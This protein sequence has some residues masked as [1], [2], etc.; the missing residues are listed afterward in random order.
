MKNVLII[1]YFFPPM[2]GSGVQ[3]TLKFVKYL[4]EFNYNPIILTVDSR[5][6]RW[7]KDKSLLEQIPP[8]TIVYR[9][10]TFDMNWL[11]KVL[12][13][14][15]LNSIVKWLLN[16]VL[17]PDAEVTWLPFAK[18]KLRIIF[19]EHKIDIVYITAG[20]FAPLLLGSYIKNKYLINYVVDFRDEWTNN[21]Y[22]NDSGISFQAKQKE[23]KYELDVL[24]NCRGIVYTHPLYMKDNFE[25]RYPFLRSKCNSIITNGFDESD[26]SQVKL[27]ETKREKLIITYIGTFYDRRQPQILWDALS[28]LFKENILD[29]NQFEFRII[30]KNKKSFVLKNYNTDQDII[31]VVRFFE[32]MMYKKSL[33]EMLNADLLLLYIATGSNSKAEMPGKLFDYLRSYKPVLAIIP[34]DG[35]A[36]EILKKSGTGLIA[37]SSDINEVKHLL[38]EVYNKWEAGALTVSPNKDYIESFNRRNQSQKLALLFDE[39]IS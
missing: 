3:K 14:L 16:N 26:F 12:W 36:A 33:Q 38:L 28:G 6:T 30:G 25:K 39:I 37:D 23:Q 5:F 20:P 19:K 18:R 8:D 22:R 13:G 4:S 9:T 21:P 35:A 29:N 32:N 15:R 24:Q 34:P 2:G 17:I 27:Q 1:A 10:P 7:I 31:E 11:F